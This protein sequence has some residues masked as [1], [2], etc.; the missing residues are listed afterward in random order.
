[1][2]NSNG[3]AGYRKDG[4]YYSIEIPKEY[5]KDYDTVILHHVVIVK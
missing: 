2:E 1:L 5:A 3:K 4:K